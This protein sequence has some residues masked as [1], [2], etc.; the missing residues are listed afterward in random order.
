MRLLGC[1]DIRRNIDVT[2]YKTVAGN[3]KP[4][5][6]HGGREHTAA[7]RTPLVVSGAISSALAIGDASGTHGS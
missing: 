4:P 1:V 3:G 5:S 2:D 7:H 6:T